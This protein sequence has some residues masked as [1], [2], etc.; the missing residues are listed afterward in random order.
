MSEAEKNL[1]NRLEVSLENL[2][3][4]NLMHIVLLA[5]KLKMRQQKA[6]EIFEK[7]NNE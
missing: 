1:R 7:R 6:D 3:A 2:S 4:Q 5:E